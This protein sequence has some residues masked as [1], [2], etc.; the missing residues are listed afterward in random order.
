MTAVDPRRYA[1]WRASELGRATD[2]LEYALMV[3]LA[4]P[5]AG[6]RVLDVGCGDGAFADHLAARGAIVTAVDADP[7]AIAAARARQ[8]PVTLM[9]G[10]A[11][12]LPF[13][14]DRF[15]VVMATTLLC[16][17][18]DP[19]RAVSEMARVTRP[20]GRVVLGEL[21]RWSL[22]ALWRR[23]RALSGGSPWR[24]ATFWGPGALRGLLTS[25]GLRAGPVRGAVYYPPVG[26][27][28]RM[29]APLDPAMGRVTAF[30][31]AFLAVAG[32]KPGSVG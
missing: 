4:G 7:A 16:L 14:D 21:G 1:V 27:V 6:R 17:V 9:V 30:G 32:D 13:G 3:Y 15:D 29:A 19:T 11:C 2:A 22:W 23:L 10:D 26:R 18:S 24:A 5:L 28:A 20:G 31:A 8:G 25:V 12:R